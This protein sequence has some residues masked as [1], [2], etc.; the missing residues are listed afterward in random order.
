[1]NTEIL[2][3]ILI[4]MT[5]VLLAIPLG[6]YCAKVYLGEKTLL[7][8]VFNPIENLFFSISGIDSKKEMNYSA[9]KL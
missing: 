4:F 9:Q 8:S 1:M 2:G 7:D 5:T 3:V 6:K